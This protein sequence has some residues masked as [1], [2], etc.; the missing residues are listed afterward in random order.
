MW[1]HKGRVHRKA[2]TILVTSEGNYDLFRS[3]LLRD[4]LKRVQGQVW[5]SFRAPL[6]QSEQAAC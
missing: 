4:V 2:S 1:L 5:P 6:Y 3:A